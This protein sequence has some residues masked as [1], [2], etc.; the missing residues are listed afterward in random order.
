MIVGLVGEAVVIAEDFFPIDIAFFELRN[1]RVPAVRTAKRGADA[2]TA[3]G[4]IHPVSH[5]P[6]DTVVFHPFHVRLVNAALV[7]QVD[8]KS[9][10]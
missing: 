8:R 6:A 10:V 4:E 1:R 7:N 3:F 2:E 5:G 9:V